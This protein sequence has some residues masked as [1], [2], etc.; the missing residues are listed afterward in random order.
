M[1]LNYEKV[2]KSKNS[3]NLSEEDISLIK[4]RIYQK[5]T[6]SSLNIRIY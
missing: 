3:K 2:L 5:I 6:L 4:G 1:L